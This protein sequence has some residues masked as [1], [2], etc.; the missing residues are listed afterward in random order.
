[1][2]N[3]LEDLDLRETLENLVLDIGQ[4]VTNNYKWVHGL[5]EGLSVE[6]VATINIYEKAITQAM[7]DA[8]PE[9]KDTHPTENGIRVETYGYEETYNQAIS[10]MESAIKKMGE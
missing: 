1:M 2:D 3:T 9:K 6:N 4:Q 10:E 7:L 5:W 8:L